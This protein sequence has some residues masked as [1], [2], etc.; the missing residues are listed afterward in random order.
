M[1]SIISKVTTIQIKQMMLIFVDKYRHFNPPSMR[2]ELKLGPYNRAE[3]SQNNTK[4][5]VSLIFYLLYG[6]ATSR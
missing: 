4:V 1:I 2:V 3:S 6:F 5:L